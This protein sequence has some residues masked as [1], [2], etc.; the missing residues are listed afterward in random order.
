VHI[1]WLDG[2]MS[3]AESFARSF[4]AEDYPNVTS[5]RGLWERAASQTDRFLSALTSDS[6]LS[7]SY[8]RA[9]GGAG[10]Q[11]WEVLLHVAMHSVQHRSEVAVMLTSAGHSPGDLDLL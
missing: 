11:M 8:Q 4:P 6:D 7:R 5:V 3:H 9:R 10:R 2:S 1:A